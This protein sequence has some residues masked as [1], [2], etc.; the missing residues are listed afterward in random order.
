MADMNNRHADE[1][2]EGKATHVG[3]KL[4]EGLGDLL[5]D[6][7]MQTEGKLDQMKGSAK[8]DIA[9]AKDALDDALGRESAADRAKKL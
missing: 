5:G 3:G 7:K 4:K 2:L 1:D 8:Q 6:H 9:H